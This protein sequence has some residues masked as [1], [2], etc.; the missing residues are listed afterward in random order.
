MAHDLLH[1]E[2]KPYIIMPLR[3]YRDLTGQRAKGLPDSVLDTLA[4]GQDH[5]VRIVRKHRGL[6][7]E[8]LAK[9]ADMSRTYLTEIETRRK[10]GSIRALKALAA[11]LD[12]DLAVL[13][14]QD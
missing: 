5:P 10:D 14:M 3:D 13:A 8:E 4:A 9:T 12:V 6:T 2:G 7:Q 11:A 1:I